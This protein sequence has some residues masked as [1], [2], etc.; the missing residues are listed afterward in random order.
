MK[1]GIQPWQM[2]DLT[3]PELDAY[4]AAVKSFM[5]ETTPLG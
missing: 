5:P 2:L 4:N 3:P 1:F